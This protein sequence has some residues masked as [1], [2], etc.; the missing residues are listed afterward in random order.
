MQIPPYQTHVAFL[1]APP[2][3][4]NRVVCSSL[5]R[6]CLFAEA[7]PACNQSRQAST[8]WA[9]MSLWKSCPPSPS[10]CPW[11]LDVG[12]HTMS[13]LTLGI[14]TRYHRFHIQKQ[15][16]RMASW[17]PLRMRLTNCLT[18]VQAKGHAFLSCIPDL[19]LML[20][21]KQTEA[22]SQTHEPCKPAHSTD[23]SESNCVRC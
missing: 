17:H 18:H 9:L 16:K 20:N 15:I 22:V 6:Q 12:T 13:G 1:S 5:P 8:S 3:A 11:L 14:Q 2:H 21:R 23:V 10:F 7:R 19:L 4:E